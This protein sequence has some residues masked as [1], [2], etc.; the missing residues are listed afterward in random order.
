[1]TKHIKVGFILSFV[2]VLIGFS[3]CL[4]DS[5]AETRRF[6]EFEALYA[7]PD[8]FRI[9]PSF[10]DERKL[11]IPGK[12]YYY[13]EMIMINER[14]EGIHIYD[15]SD[16]SAPESLGFLAI[17][18]NL[19]VAIKNDIMYA[20]SYVDLL[21]I[22]VSDLRNPSLMCR[23]ELVFDNYNWR[24][25]DIRGYFV[26]TKETNREIEID[27][28]DPNFGNNF[29]W[30]AQED[31]IFIDAANGGFDGDVPTTETSAGT[32]AGAN[33]ITGVGGSFARFSVL[34]DYLYVLNMRD[35]VSY[36]LSNPL[37]PEKTATTSVG[38]QIETLFPY[39]NNLFIG[40][41]N[42]MFIYDRVDP[43]APQFVSAFRHANACDPVFVRDDIAYVTLRNGTTCQN[44]INQLDVLDV[45]NIRSPQLIESFDMDHPHGLA[46]RANNLY[47]CEGSHGLKVFEND[48]LRKIDDNRIA[49]IK[50]IDAYDVISLAQDHLLII[51]ADGL[52]QYD[53]S[54]P[55]DLELLSFL[56]STP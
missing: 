32:T 26:G 19:D 17:P 53:S 7:H 34:D 11:E 38:W 15:N 29:F 5:C 48:D 36:N 10:I 50:D 3:S 6:V 41:N 23:D 21:T 47:I 13:N 9:E 39:K 33:A 42:G 12:I 55:S 51:G 28:S 52:Y 1:M 24:E 43:A 18:G 22:D 25:N 31:V 4:E 27:C 14:Y 46:V 37:K 54:D 56:P 45:S 40:G 8:D 20:D 16:P 2:A 49:H 35:L 30:G 44:F